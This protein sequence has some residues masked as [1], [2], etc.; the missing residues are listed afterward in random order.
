MAPGTNRREEYPVRWIAVVLLAISLIAASLT[1]VAAGES[2]PALD[3]YGK[4]WCRDC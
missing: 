2:S 4:G 1:V 3:P